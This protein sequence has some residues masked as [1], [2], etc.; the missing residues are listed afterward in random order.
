MFGRNRLA[1]GS[2]ALLIAVALTGC[3]GSSTLPTAVPTATPSAADTPTDTPAPTATETATPSPT[4]VP[5]ESAT[6]IATDTP[7]PEPSATATSPAA[8]CT[9]TADHQAFF[10]LAAG[11]L[12]FDLYCAVLPSGWYLQEAA[13][14][15]PNGGQFTVSY[16]GPGGATLSMSEGAFCTTGEAAC[17]P[18]VSIRGTAT[19]GPLPGVIDV[20]TTP[21]DAFVIYVNPGTTRAYTVQC[22]NLTQA[23]FI[24]LAAALTK[25]PKS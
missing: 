23:K 11:K 14:Q 3:S 25:V 22:T 16:K 7:S 2:A 10:V 13:Y 9:G 20:L 5:V 17:S 19:F 4:Q 12:A 24:A 15:Q 21:P 8:A 18:H 1:M 6:P